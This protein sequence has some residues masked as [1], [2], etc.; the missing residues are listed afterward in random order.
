[1]LRLIGLFSVLG[2]VLAIVG[3]YGVLAEFV[4]QRVPEIGVRM[5]VGATAADVLALVLGHGARLV[6]LGVTLGLAGAVLLRG[7]MTTFIYGVQPFDLQAYATACLLL[8]ATTMAACTV[9]ARRASRLD[10]VVALRTE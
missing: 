5:A 8:L 3:V 7:A 4:V 2:L 9:P 10:P 6:A 1:M